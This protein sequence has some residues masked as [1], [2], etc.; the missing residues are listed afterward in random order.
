MI[1]LSAVVKDCSALQLVGRAPIAIQTQ[2]GN[3]GS[4]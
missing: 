1:V 4:Q 2:G 3:D